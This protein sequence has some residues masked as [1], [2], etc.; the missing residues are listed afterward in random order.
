MTWDPNAYVKLL[1]HREEGKKDKWLM[2]L[3]ATAN[4]YGWSE[5]FPTW[6]IRPEAEIGGYTFGRDP[7][8]KGRLQFEGGRRHYVCRSPYTGGYPRGFTNAFKLSAN[9]GLAD[10]AEVAEFTKGE[11]Y[12]MNGPH[13]ERLKRDEWH[14][15]YLASR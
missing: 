7:G 14:T 6:T 10:I 11:W 3:R 1:L 12:W 9:C 2:A 15:L 5:E 4:Y 13:G 8:R